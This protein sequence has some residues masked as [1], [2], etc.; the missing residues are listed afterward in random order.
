MSRAFVSESNDD[1]MESDIPEVKY[2]LPEGTKN[3][4]TPDGAEKIMEEL[5][6]LCTVRR[7]ELLERISSAVTYD[8]GDRESILQDRRKLCEVDRRIEYLRKMVD[9]LEVVEHDMIDRDHVHFGALVTVEEKTTGKKKYRIVGVDE[10]DPE[11]GWISWHSPLARALTGRKTGETVL[12]QT[13]AG[14]LQL[15]IRGIEY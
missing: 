11:K 3:Y 13:P 2:P 9:N 12:V 10:S 1:F 8:R 4:M 15:L 6:E 7:P 5:N 14:E